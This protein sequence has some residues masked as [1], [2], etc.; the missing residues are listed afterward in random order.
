[1]KAVTMRMARKYPWLKCRNVF[2]GK[3]VKGAN[4][5]D[6]LPK[7]WQI[8]F[9]EQMINELD[10]LLKKYK[11]T[12]QY[13]VMQVKE[14]YGELRWYAGPMPDGLYQEHGEWEDKYAELSGAVCYFCGKPA[15]TITK[16]WILHVCDK[17]KKEGRDNE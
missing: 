8:A 4:W 14:K 1:M 3:L 2:T 5:Y 15:T 13:R 6:N 9:G 11:Y 16:G 17:H 10:Q 12:K 7:G